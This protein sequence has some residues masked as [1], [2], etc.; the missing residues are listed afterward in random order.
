MV[1]F[2]NDLCAFNALRPYTHYV[3]YL[4]AMKSLVDAYAGRTK[5]TGVEFLGQRYSNEVLLPDV[6]A[7]PSDYFASYPRIPGQ[8]T[9]HPPS[10]YSCRWS[11]W[12]KDRRCYRYR[13]PPT[14]H[15]PTQ[16]LSKMR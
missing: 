6:E 10:R 5:P 1:Q 9:R 8:D 13:V 2:A 16:P 7:D 15:E 3:D 4:P 14:A 12:S 11:N